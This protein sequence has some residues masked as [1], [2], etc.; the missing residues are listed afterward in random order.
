MVLLLAYLALLAVG[1]QA[2]RHRRHR[3]L[4][5]NTV[6]YRALSWLTVGWANIRDHLRTLA[7]CLQLLQPMVAQT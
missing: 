1:A 3:C 2:E 6:R 7:T 4:M 5:A